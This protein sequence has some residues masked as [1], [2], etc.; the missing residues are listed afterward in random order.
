VWDRFVTPADEINLAGTDYNPNLSVL[1]LRAAKNFRMGGSK[2][3]VATIEL[4]NVTNSGAATTV[5][6][7]YG[8]VGTSRAFGSVSAVIPPARGRVGIEFKF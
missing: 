3:F 5:N 8:A 7:Q 6:Y 1:D 4:F 2:R